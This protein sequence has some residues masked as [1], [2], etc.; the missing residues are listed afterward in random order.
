[1]ILETFAHIEK[2]TVQKNNKLFSIWKKII[3]KINGCGENVY[4]HTQIADLKNGVLMIE[5]DH[6]GWIQLLQMH[7]GFIKKGLKMYVPEFNI[8]SL[9]FRLKGSNSVLHNVDYDAQLSQGRQKLM[10]E[11]EAEGKILEKYGSP[12]AQQ[13]ENAS[14]SPEI[15]E[16]FDSIKRS[17]LT[18]NKNK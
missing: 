13:S 10:Q 7:S 11:M 3:T 8:T 14:L 1:M 18:K 5:A 17:L 2:S 16:K 9:A 6:S 12:E 4:E 15:Q